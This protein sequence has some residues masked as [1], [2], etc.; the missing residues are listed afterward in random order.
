MRNT[1]ETEDELRAHTQLITREVCGWTK[2]HIDT[3]RAAAK[4]VAG[5]A[6]RRGRHRGAVRF[7]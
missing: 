7:V 6:G 3:G 4:A 1:K 2:R 5:G